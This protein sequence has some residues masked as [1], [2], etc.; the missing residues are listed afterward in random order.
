MIQLY[1]AT[2]KSKTII[3]GKDVDGDVKFE[4]LPDDPTKNDLDI[5]IRK[6]DLPVLIQFLTD[7]E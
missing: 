1:D 2:N 3:W 6:E 4:I 5:Y 7:Q